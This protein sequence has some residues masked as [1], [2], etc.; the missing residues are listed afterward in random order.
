M[1]RKKTE[2]E[3]NECREIEQ[4]ASKKLETALPAL[5]KALSAVEKLNKDAVTEVKS[6]AKPPPIVETV[7]AAVMTIL[8]LF[9]F[10][11]KKNS[12]FLNE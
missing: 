11:E 2:K 1:E 6:Y 8:G 9:Q 12:N 10:E 3:E 4:Q 7:L 5:Q